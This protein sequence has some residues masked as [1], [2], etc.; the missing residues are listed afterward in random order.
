MSR[1]TA[2]L[3]FRGRRAS[4][5]TDQPKKAAST[6]PFSVRLASFLVFV[7]FVVWAI[8]DEVQW[9]LAG[10]G[11]ALV[12]LVLAVLARKVFAPRKGS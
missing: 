9:I 6:N 7:G 11:C 4:R 3:V 10:I 8:S 1:S 2:I 12:V 5:V